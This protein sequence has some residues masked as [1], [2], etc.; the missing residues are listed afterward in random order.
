[1]SLYTFRRLKLLIKN[2]IA[3]EIFI[4]LLETLIAFLSL[5]PQICD[6]ST[7]LKVQEKWKSNRKIVEQIY[8]NE[9]LHFTIFKLL[10]RNCISSEI[11]KILDEIQSLTSNLNFIKRYRSR[12]CQE[13]KFSLSS[14][15][16]KRLFICC[17]FFRYK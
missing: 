17:V 7:N 14:S 12:P 11:I 13:S 2:Y 8:E 5:L 4:I 9:F 10:I 16:A 1:M 3:F 15:F 6:L